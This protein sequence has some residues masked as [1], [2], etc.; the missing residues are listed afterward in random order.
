ML[1]MGGCTGKI[2][3]KIVQIQTPTFT[4]YYFL[5]IAKSVLFVIINE[6]GFPRV[7]DSCAYVCS[8]ICY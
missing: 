7:S 5:F 3:N 6:W 1:A 4:K 2:D 8:D